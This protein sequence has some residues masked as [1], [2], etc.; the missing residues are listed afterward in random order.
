LS[1]HTRICGNP[2]PTRSLA[3]GGS[4]DPDSLGRSNF[5]SYV[6]GTCEATSDQGCAPPLEIQSWPACE[7]SA[8]DYSGG[9][10]DN[11]ERLE[12]IEKFEL[13]GVP[14]RLYDDVSVELSTGAVTVV[15]FGRTRAQLLAA[16]K[17]L[18]GEA[19]PALGAGPKEDLPSPTAGAQEGTLSC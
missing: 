13:R 1:A 17:E 12:P 18:R 15:I 6:Y 3:A 19:G 10:P 8:A 4:V 9:S 5:D 2:D 7:R 16:A 11:P 14:A